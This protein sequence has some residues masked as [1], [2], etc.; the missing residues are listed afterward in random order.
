M[1]NRSQFVRPATEAFPAPPIPP[2]LPRILLHEEAPFYVDA[3][4]KEKQ[5]VIGWLAMFLGEC[6]LVA[7]N[8]DLLSALLLIEQ[9]DID[10]QYVIER[11]DSTGLY[12]I[13]SGLADLVMTVD[14]MVLHTYRHGIALPSGSD[15][16][17]I[18]AQA[19][20]GQQPW[21]YIYSHPSNERQLSYILRCEDRVYDI[22][23]WR[24]RVDTE[25]GER[26]TSARFFTVRAGSDQLDWGDKELDVQ[27]LSLEGR[28]IG[29]WRY[30]RETYP[31]RNIQRFWKDVVDP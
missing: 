23:F 7:R 13:V 27:E 24:D 15:L 26:I 1:E 6:R 3:L 10:R 29:E 4:P 19:E 12:Q 14:S 28:V 21:S 31:E 25:H 11:D 2:I 17:K 18:E 22:S 9:A 16:E 5:G 30:N 8:L 20:I